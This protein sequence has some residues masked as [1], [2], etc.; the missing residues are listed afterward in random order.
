MIDYDDDEV[1]WWMREIEYIVCEMQSTWEEITAQSVAKE[2]YDMYNSCS[3][4]SPPMDGLLEMCYDYLQRYRDPID[5]LGDVP[6]DLKF[7]TESGKNA[8]LKAVTAKSK[9]LKVHAA[10]LDAYAEAKFGK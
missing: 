8:L 5:G 10:K 7:L 1:R 6:S 2:L 9:L 3:S 4:G